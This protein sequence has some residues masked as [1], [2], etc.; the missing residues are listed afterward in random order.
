MGDWGSCA[1]AEAPAWLRLSWPVPRL[2]FYE[3]IWW[4]CVIVMMRWSDDVT[5]IKQTA[6]LFTH[7][8]RRFPFEKNIYPFVAKPQTDMNVLI[9]INQHILH[10][11]LQVWNCYFN[12]SYPDPWWVS[13]MA[14]K[15]WPVVVTTY[16]FQSW[17]IL[18]NSRVILFRPLIGLFLWAHEFVV[19]VRTFSM[20]TMIK[21]V[22]PRRPI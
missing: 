2:F 3:K 12:F 21:N 4:L 16:H 8:N 7:T 10:I 19:C 18:E 5:M 13:S 1:V 9:Q 20:A 17:I 15:S 11:L 22:P 6:F 14:P